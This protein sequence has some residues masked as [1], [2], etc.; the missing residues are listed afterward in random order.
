M[1]KVLI[2]I[3][4][5][6]LI[7]NAQAQ[8]QTRKRVITGKTLEQQT[9]TPVEFANVLLYNAKDSSLVEYTSTAVGGGFSLEIDKTGAFY[10]EIASIGYEKK[11]IPLSLTDA[12]E[13]TI[14]LGDIDIE[15]A[16]LELSE[17]AVTG[18][19][20]QIV[21]KLDKRVIEASGF[22][23]AAGGTAVDILAQ[24]PSIRVDAEGEVT[25]RGS[26]G[27]K[28]YIDGKPSSLEGTIALEQ[29]P[30]GQI[31]NIEVITV[32]SA[33]NDADG[34]A[35]IININLK[36][37]ALDG[38]SGMVNVM[39]ST[40]LSRNIDF[41]TALR[42]ND[43]RWQVSGEAS[44]R[45]R[46]SDF[47]QMKTVT[48]PEM[49]TTDHSFGTRE[50]YTDTYMLRTGADW[51]KTNTTWS[52]AAEVGYRDRWRGGELKYED[53]YRVPGSDEVTDDFFQGDDY[54]RLNGWLL[55]GDAGFNHRF[56]KEGHRLTG[57]LYALY[58]NH[59]LE[60]FETNL[61]DMAGKR[62]QGHKAW[63]EEFRLTSQLNLD[64]VLPLAT[65]E[66]KFEAGYQFY[67]YTEDGDYRIDMFDPSEGDFV[68]RD[69]LYNRYVF[70][71]DIHAMYAMLS[72]TWQRF[73]YQIGVRGE[74]TYRKLA[75]NLKWAE[76][77]LHNF[78]LYP[79]VHLALALGNGARTNLSYSRRITQPQLFYMEPY[80]VYVDYYTAQ[81]G[82]PFI[83][84]EY[85]NSVEWGYNQNFG[86]NTL[87]GTLFYR[88][89]K[90]KIERVRV[91][92]QTG[93]TL[94]SMA[95]VG[96]DYA[97]GAELSTMIQLNK[98][99]NLD[100]NG[101]LY[102]YKVKNEYKI[103]GQDAESWNW[104]L[105][106]NNN[107][108]IGKTTRARFEAYYVGPSVNSQG[109]IEDFFYMNLTVRQQLFNRRLIASLNIRDVLATAQ[110]NS[111]QRNSQ[112]E[113][114]TSIIPQSPVFTLTLSYTFNNFGGSQRA[115]RVNHDLFEGTNR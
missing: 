59:A 22:L 88:A 104:Q 111:V 26:S 11:Q 58:E 75:N 91:P 41:L 32:P 55:R 89:R 43:V 49:I 87:T 1:K 12:S 93:V 47:D 78:G 16:S 108:D 68:R 102:Y 50:S 10:I 42:Q 9:N 35:G 97:S 7:F 25:F 72:N 27:F 53:T 84:P 20:R 37:Q 94:D 64:Y 106:V 4:V 40:E 57:T 65:Q 112:V 115:E 39:G 23:S 74:Y 54:V 46:R 17:V 80:I 70:R 34:T 14:A 66:D 18:Q 69:D 71:R 45:Y 44:R 63:E 38:W 30:A 19:R 29:I 82:N 24:T 31:E 83:K 73:S 85:T 33:R 60:Y 76:H 114:L 56:A 48:T 77:R 107:F 51:Y 8:S 105:A 13:Q 86:S 99:W 95:N 67:T 103:D 79:S 92:Y 62:A 113:S 100:A 36:K 6:L 81:R 21:Y 109:R 61:Y 90:D 2:G 28:V 110:Y 96:S 3:I 5:C 15:P 52:A 98:W 101:S